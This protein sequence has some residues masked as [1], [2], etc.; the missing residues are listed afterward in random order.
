MFLS[1]AR[2]PTIWTPKFLSNFEELKRERNFRLGV[3]G[4][5]L[6]SAPYF[7]QVLEG[8]PE[9]IGPLFEV[10]RR[11]PLHDKCFVLGD[12]RCTERLYADWQFRAV[13]T[14]ELPV[15][16]ANVLPQMAGAF[17]SMWRYLPRSAADLLLQGKDPRTHPPRS[18]EVA[19]C[20]VQ[21]VEFN[22]ILAQPLLA[23]HLADLLDVFVGTCIKHTTETGGEFAKFVNGVV[24]LFWPATHAACA[25]E[26]LVAMLDSFAALRQQQPR[27]SALSFFH[28]HAGVHY[29]P[30]LLCN[31]GMRKADFT[32]L[33]DAVNVAARLCSKAVE[34]KAE[35]LLSADMRR[36]MGAPD[37]ALVAM[38]P[39][40]LKGRSEPVECY[41]S[42]GPLVDGDAVR[43]RVEQFLADGRRAVPPQRPV[44][45][46]DDLPSLER[47]GIFEDVLHQHIVGQPVAV[48]K[49]SRL[50]CCLLWLARRH[51]VHEETE[52]FQLISILYLSRATARLS[53]SEV[54]HIQKAGT[55]RNRALGI[56]SELICLDGLLMHTVEGPPHAVG[57]LWDRLR[58][59]PRHTELV[60]V[61]LV[62]I[63][64]RTCLRPLDVQ[65]LT[66]AALEAL[67]IL[68][69]L[70]GQMA[71]SFSCL[72][73]YVPHAVVRHIMAEKQP[74][75]MPPILVT[76]VM[77]ATDI[78]S[79]TPLSEGCPLTE[80]WHLC[81]TFIDL[82]TEEI[83]RNR[84]HVLKLVG[85]CVK[86]YFPA[87]AA[88]LALDAARGII[89]ACTAFRQ[90]VHRLDCRSVMACGVGLDCG[91][92]V[93]AH[94]GTEQVAKLLVTGEAASR[95][96]EVEALTRK[97]GR[98]VVLT[99]PVAQRL[100]AACPLDRLPLT[101]GM[102][103]TPCYA[104]PGPEYQMD[105]SRVNFAIT[106]FHDACRMV[107][108]AVVCDNTDTS[109][110][111]LSSPNSSPRACLSPVAKQP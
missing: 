33:G 57:E 88:P 80:V 26:G 23:E 103:R 6:F 28:V 79:F 45:Q 107:R 32:L 61:H 91:P 20:F 65:V 66:G 68:P 18:Q 96:M 8:F 109:T 99:Q 35:L 3:S 16:V 14:A 42:P 29:G 60:V 53:S 25:Y 101:P 87:D 69:E 48:S 105:C 73:T 70:L 46:Y 89:R 59:D 31:A 15:T 40:Q 110:V 11:N 84:G 90:K 75:R 24:M 93:M 22:S 30:A 81:T 95:V 102:D 10:I 54:D 38:G 55:R 92:V 85:D 77:M 86:A 9:V 19:V 94:C 74:T 58:A 56:T 5:L 52:G 12:V 63:Q 83:Q 27:N 71:R 72:E 36:A 37:D 106:A 64:T 100:P 43:L 17:L 13:E 67:P 21:V 39:Q 62:P 104:L 98:Q 108:S 78:V 82:C 47:P 44:R 49:P 41:R 34:L 76:V 51:N 1:V 2:D 7:F 50:Q 97:V 111:A 4:F